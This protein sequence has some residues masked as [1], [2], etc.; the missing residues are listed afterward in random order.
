MKMSHRDINNLRR[1]LGLKGKPKSIDNTITDKEIRIVGSR[2]AIEFLHKY[3]NLLEA[4]KQRLFSDIEK[5]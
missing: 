2:F 4:E 3:Y 5:E 1:R